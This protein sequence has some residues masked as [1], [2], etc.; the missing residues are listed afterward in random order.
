[1]KKLFILIFILAP[2][3]AVSQDNVPKYEFRGT[4]IATVIN[5]DWPQSGGLAPRFQKSDL[6]NKLNKLDE[7]GINI[8]FFQ[9]R[10]E[11]DALYDS[12]IEP[13][14]KYLTGEE[15]KAPEPYWDPLTFVIEEAHKQGM[16]LHAWL[17]PYRA[18][19]TIPSDFSQKVS[20]NT[21]KDVYEI[22]E[23]LKRPAEVDT[24]LAN[25]DKAK[26]VLNWKPKITFDELVAQMVESDLKNIS[27]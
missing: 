15:G 27:N 18:M 22:D 25:F 24:L 20:A 16:E 4:W 12:P 21:N 14:S 3:L 17:N 8:V 1:M 26:K 2:V 7:L 9:I 11:G 23:S 6:I 10:T 19:R 13:W 5:L